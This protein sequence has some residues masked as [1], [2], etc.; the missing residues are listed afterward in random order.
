MSSTWKSLVKGL[1]RLTN[2]GLARPFKTV[3]ER[4][5]VDM[6]WVRVAVVTA[7]LV[8]NHK[9]TFCSCCKMNKVFTN[10]WATV[11][12]P[13]MTVAFN[14]HPEFCPRDLDRGT[15]TNSFCYGY[16]TS[17]RRIR[18]VCK[19]GS[20]NLHSDMNDGETGAFHTQCMKYDMYVCINTYFKP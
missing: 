1:E 18:I 13:V 12:T 10:R 14:I 19:T 9:S 16:E 15:Y 11:H 8:T 2:N 7:S 20:H 6:E 4:E 17:V 5:E 3:R